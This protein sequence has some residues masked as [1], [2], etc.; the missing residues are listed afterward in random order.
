MGYY[1]KATAITVSVS[2]MLLVSAKLITSKTLTRS[3]RKYLDLEA[4]L[5]NLNIVSVSVTKR[6]QDNDIVLPLHISNLVDSR[7]VHDMNFLLIM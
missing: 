7:R 1:G 3:I 2:G 5:P 6:G 4:Q